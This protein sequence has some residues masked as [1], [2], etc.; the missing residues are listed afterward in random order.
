MT[1]PWEAAESDAPSV[2]Q[3]C[4]ACGWEGMMTVVRNGEMDSGMKWRVFQC[5]G[6][7][8]RWAKN[9]NWR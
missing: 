9:G 3:K 1:A 8:H 6:C 4:P 2:M 7:A 5:R